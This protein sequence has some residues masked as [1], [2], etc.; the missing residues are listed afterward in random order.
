MSQDDRQGQTAGQSSART[1][2]NTRRPLSFAQERLWFIEQLEPGTPVYNVPK[3]YRIRGTLDLDSLRHALSRIANRH[4]V[5]RTVFRAPGGIPEQITRP[6]GSVDCQLVDLSHHQSAQRTE[7]LRE[8]LLEEAA[9]PFD[10]TS[11]LM[12]RASVYRLSSVEHVLLVVMHHIATDGWSMNLLLRELAA[13]YNAA[14]RGEEAALAPLPMQY[15]DF[16]S[17]QREHL[18]AEGASREL[19]YWRRQLDSAPPDVDLP[20]DRVRPRIPDYRGARL[21]CLMPT[22]AARNVD[23]M[24][25]GN[26]ATPFMVFVS[27]LFVLLGRYSGQSDLSIGAPVAGRSDPRLE[28]M[29]G[30]FVNMLVIR[31]RVSADLTFSELL[32]AVRATCLDAY[33][34]QALPFERLVALLHPERMRHRTPFF[35]VSLSFWPDP[36]VVP[37]FADLALEPV[38]IDSSFAKFDLSLS[39]RR[40]GE[41]YAVSL[42]YP[43]ALFDQRTVHRFLE[44][45]LH[46]CGWACEHP[47]AGVSTIELAAPE[48]ATRAIQP[49]STEGTSPAYPRSIVAGFREVAKECPE[50]VALELGTQRMTYRALDGASDRLAVSLIERGTSVS[51]AVG[52]YLE[53][54]FD[55]VLAY[56]GI[57][58]ARGCYVPVDPREPFGRSVELLKRAGVRRVLTIMQ[59]SRGLQAEGLEVIC[60][61][62]PGEFSASIS[63]APDLLP[64]PQFEDIAYIIFTSGSTGRPKGVRVPHRGVLRLVKEADYVELGARTRV[65]HLAS[66]SFDAA[67]FEVWGPLLNGGTCVLSPE[68]VPSVSQLGEL[69]RTSHINTLWLTAT[70]FNA[71]IDEDASVLDRLGELLIGGEALSVPHVCRALQALPDTQIINGYGPTEDTTFTCCYR[72]PRTFDCRATS[73]PIGRPIRGTRVYVLDELLRPVAPGVPGELV[74]GGSGLS[75]GYVNDDEPGV[76]FIPDPLDPR[77]VEQVYRSGDRVRQLPSGELEFLGRMDRQLKVRG[78]RVEPREIEFVLAQHPAVHDVRV[79]PRSHAEGGPKHLVAYIVPAPGKRL[80]RETLTNFAEGRLPDYMV[81]SH[82]VEVAEF[83]RQASGKL[84]ARA[85]TDVPSAGLGSGSAVHPRSPVE[86]RLA[87]IWREL[88]RLDDV[89][90]RSTF[91]ELGGHSL[92]AVRLVARIESAFNVSLPLAV[93]FDSP[94]IEALAKHIETLGPAVS[95]STVVPLR[96]GGGAP[97]FCVPPAGASVYH[98]SDLVQRLSPA[99]DFYGI[100]PL[101]LEPGETPQR[102]IEEM[103][104]RYVRDLRTMEPEGP[105]ALGGRCLGA[106]VA[107]EM[108]QQLVADGQ[109]VSLLAL[110]DP[111]APPGIPRNARY[112]AGRIGYFRRRGAL[113]PAALRYLRVRI[114]GLRKLWISGLL[115]NALARRLARVQRVQQRAQDAYRPRPYPGDLVFLAAE[116]GYHPED[117]RAL[118]RNLTT[119]RFDLRLMPGGHRSITQE[120]NLTP[121]AQVLESLILRAHGRRTGTG[122]DGVT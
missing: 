116:R 54:S 102:S 50:A 17:W 34:H 121:F 35:Q 73:V 100:Q 61:D 56:L 36:E 79:L 92:L 95:R 2:G 122:T 114:V 70:W 69:I 74:I 96:T 28:S 75:L 105:Y 51:E 19:A 88:L 64:D 98:F 62:R 13:C 33:E 30:F 48:D 109:E 45:Y 22:E 107:F 39:I 49:L 31:E 86:K 10:L 14:R 117:N 37:D 84:D 90:V 71:V 85:L 59:H 42:T 26:R 57:L 68:R 43:T 40:A 111:A 5:I 25:S 12:L 52:V 11:D 23:S 16:A 3:A 53:R 91:F 118:W 77:S 20:L 83:P 104:A 103:A 24:A 101:G 119:G 67:T 87:A 27:V 9:R 99:I 41:T 120:P 115:A 66:P 8:A 1:L 97:F 6:I 113:L 94:T 18:D 21:S 63:Q 93:L 7:K 112:Y 55:S 78:F 81:P 82:F 110:I 15:P 80:E 47:E 32:R 46:A 65:L 72:I 89:S 108:A 29:I 38:D 4:E 106:F 76:R 58:K 60:L 44:Q